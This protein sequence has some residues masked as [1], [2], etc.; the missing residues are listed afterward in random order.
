V[1]AGHARISILDRGTGQLQTLVD[2]CVGLRLNSPNDVV[3]KSDGTVWFTD[4]SYGHLQGFKPQPL[5]SDHVYR[6]DP[7]TGALSVVA[8]SFDKPNGLVF[9]PDETVLYVGNWD[10][11][12]K[13][14]MR[15]EMDPSGTAVGADV[16]CDLTGASGE[17]PVDGL[18]VDRA[19]N[20]YVCGPSGIWVLSPDG[21]HL[22][23]IHLPEAP[24][25]PAWGDD[26]AR[27]AG[28]G[29]GRRATSS[30]PTCRTC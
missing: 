5:L 8:D 25:N 4:P 26:D 3:V 23:T 13:L 6:H 29:A 16:F 18:T 10:Q 12:R 7:A 11:R 22:G 14:V 1:R 2:E 17:D 19:G 28:S 21:G 24:H 27:R 15:Y 9:S 30:G 20:L